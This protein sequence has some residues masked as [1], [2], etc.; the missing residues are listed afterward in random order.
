[1]YKNTV[2]LAIYMIILSIMSPLLITPSITIAGQDNSEYGS[3]ELGSQYRPLIFHCSI[4]PLT[5]S[6]T[7]IYLNA[8][9]SH[10]Y[11]SLSFS[12]GKFDYKFQVNVSTAIKKPYLTIRKTNNSLI[13]IDHTP[14][15]IEVAPIIPCKMVL[16]PIRVQDHEIIFQLNIYIGK[17]KY[18]DII[19]PVIREMLGITGILYHGRNYKLSNYVY[20]VRNLSQKIVFDTS[21]NH[22]EIDGIDI[23]FFP[24]YINVLKNAKDIEMLYNRGLLKFSFKGF[25]GNILYYLGHRLFLQYSGPHMPL[26]IVSDSYITIKE[27]GKY[28]YIYVPE[29]IYFIKYNGLTATVPVS[30]DVFIH[31]WRYNATYIISHIKGFKL[32]RQ[33]YGW[34]NVIKHYPICDIQYLYKYPV[35][36]D[37]VLP[38][39]TNNTLFNASYILIKNI[40][41]SQQNYTLIENYDVG[42]LPSK[43]MTIETGNPL[44]LYVLITIIVVP[45]IIIIALVIRRWL[46]RKY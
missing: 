10:G 33:E 44:L 26:E 5:R 37:L 6:L 9:T 8:S 34:H 14:R 38:L 24:L 19:P 22:A 40:R 41:L 25:Y 20:G 39:P 23:G 17:I 43:Y 1:M 29:P 36:G 4:I 2:Y 18:Y 15:Y 12:A 28:E 16:K 7:P 31:P 30:R 11:G 32:I 3:I 27:I 46:R 45:S 35:S 13:I 42:Y 21:N